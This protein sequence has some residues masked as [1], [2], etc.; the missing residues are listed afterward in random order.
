MESASKSYVQGIWQRF[1]YLAT[2]LPN[3]RLQLGDIG[4]QEG[5]EFRRVTSLA[6]LGVTF[7]VRSGADRV[8]FTYTSQSGVTIRT[9]AKGEVGVGTALPGAQAGISIEFGEAGA[10][11]FQAMGCSVDEIEDK[12]AVGRAAIALF[13]QGQWQPQWRL[14]D[15]LVKADSATIVVSNSQ[16][17]ALELSAKVP[18]TVADLA[19]AEAGLAVNAQRGDVIRF[20]AARGLSP[21]F[22]LSR[23]KQS[24]LQR[25]FG[26]GGPITFG[27]PKAGVERDEEAAAPPENPL[28]EVGP[29]A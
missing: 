13:Q 22:K 4:V 24:L 3:T 29:V 6:D 14:V 1:S 7:K 18:V 25:W 19:N 16:N 5:E 17:A 8:D 12:A 9:N 15:T 27:G 28:E 11:L 23:V 21:L 26:G 10:F 20:I 2:W